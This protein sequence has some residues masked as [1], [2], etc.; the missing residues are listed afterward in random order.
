MTIRL[1]FEL[2]LSSD[3]HIG[4]GQRAGMTVDA[5]LLRD[6]NGNPVLRGTTLVGL[7]RDGFDALHHQIQ[8]NGLDK[9][10]DDSAR[11]RLLGAADQKK[12][13]T[14]SSAKLVGGTQPMDQRWGAQDV[15][16]IRMN[17]R[18]RRVSPQQLFF[19][20]EGDARLSFRFT[21]TCYGSN[22]EDRKDALLLVA[23]ARKVRHL[24][25]TR[26]RGRG[27]CRI[28]LINAQNCLTLPPG[29]TWTETTL[30]TFKAV[31][32]QGELLPPP[33]ETEQ[34]TQTNIS[35][36]TDPRRLRLLVHLQEPVLI[37]DK[38]EKGNAFE[39]LL[40]IPGAA[41]LGALAT[42]A[43]RSIRLDNTPGADHQRF[44]DMFIKGGIQVSGL[45][46]AEPDGNVSNMTKLWPAVPTPRSLV[47]CEVHPQYGRF[48]DANPHEVQNQVDEFH[49]NCHCG[50][51]LKDIG[52]FLRLD[53]NLS[54]HTIK[55][56]EEIH[57]KVNPKTGRV[58]EGDLFTYQLIEAG[59]WYVGELLCQP[60]YWAD[61]CR[62]TGMNL[63]QRHNLRLGKATRRGYGLVHVVYQDIPLEAPASWSLLPLEQ[64]LPDPVDGKITTTLLLL[65]DTILADPWFSFR[66]NFDAASI[67]RLLSLSDV[68]RIEIVNQMCGSRSLDAFNT[69]RRFPRWRDE[70]MLAGSV[71]RFSVQVK[72]KDEAVRLLQPIEQAGIGWRQ[73]EG[74]GRVA[75]AHPVFASV[76][77]LN[78]G[79]TVPKAVRDL[80]ITPT[81]D[82]HAAWRE[83]A[84]RKEWSEILDKSQSKHADDWKAIK[85]EYST[86]ARLL[87]L[88]RYSTITEVIKLLA[89]QGDAFAA[90]GAAYLWGSKKLTG[91]E[92][93][94]KIEGNGL[95]RIQELLAQLQKRP[96][97]LWPLGL[98]LLAE[99]VGQQ[100][101][102]TREQGGEK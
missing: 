69:Y 21:A 50:G 62:W 59:Q 6:H 18:T 11:I 38:S 34:T 77:E 80:F 8:E 49:R 4:A 23:V 96:S 30:Q 58:A 72:D 60:E 9:H 20:E 63:N 28:H 86:I 51:K 13:W 100:V 40:H 10:W 42:R 29:K 31:W 39:T 102:M 27:E 71:V 101:E 65:T 85:S 5:A 57:T 46:P 73:N 84:F 7:L 99:R 66:R 95:K 35:Q 43:A 87:F 3:Y 67:A 24:G 98:T 47:Q 15:A 92:A 17:P 1:T 55:K 68:T 61:L 70:V 91:R 82:L 83:A 33:P 93:S 54:S 75:F 16:R 32:L 41:V 64:R 19:E 81:G 14:F 78:A 79:L 89:I 22:E 37:A 76:N 25:A 36:P 94:T 26:R 97:S 2:T 12:R 88:Y 56:R 53:A 52:G 74:F 48:A 45:F 44:S 90:P